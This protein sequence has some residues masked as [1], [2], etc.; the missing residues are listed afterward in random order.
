VQRIT[1]R[2]SPHSL[3]VHA[4]SQVQRVAA[5]QLWVKLR[6]TQCE[7]MFSAL[8]SNADILCGG[9]D[10]SE[11]PTAEAYDVMQ[12]ANRMPVLEGNH[13]ILIQVRLAGNARFHPAPSPISCVKPGVQR[14]QN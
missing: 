11:G 2:W 5:D 4:A 6:R 8:P 13:S 7:H 9:Q 12:R 14:G 10:V 3:R 1:S